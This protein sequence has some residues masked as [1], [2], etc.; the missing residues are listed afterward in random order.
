MHTFVHVQVLVECLRL[1]EALKLNTEQAAVAGREIVRCRAFEAIIEVSRWVDRRIVDLPHSTLGV[2]NARLE[3]V[4]QSA[5]VVIE[6]G[7]TDEVVATV[8]FD[9]FS[10]GHVELRDLVLPEELFKTLVP[11]RCGI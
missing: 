6:A 3:V 7:C 1:G 10:I 4:H 5:S 9:C 8:A 11:W 2:F